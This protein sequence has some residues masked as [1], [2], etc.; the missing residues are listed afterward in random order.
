VPPP[1][2]EELREGGMG[3]YFI[4]ALMDEVSFESDGSGT[5]V[6][7]IKYRPQASVAGAEAGD[8]KRG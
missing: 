7:M 5:V 4:R 1:A 2:P 6:Q 8:V 3:V